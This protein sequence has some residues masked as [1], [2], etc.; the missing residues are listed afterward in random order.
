LKEAGGTPKLT[1]YPDAGHDAWTQAYNDE[2]LYDW[3]L[4]HKRGE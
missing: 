3:F 1:I 2:E 4:K